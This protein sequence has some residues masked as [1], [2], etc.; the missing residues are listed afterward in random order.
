M[1]ET[2]VPLFVVFCYIM[3]FLILTG[4]ATSVLC[5]VV[6]APGKFA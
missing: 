2:L 3:Q 5:N 1:R 4:Q 6:E